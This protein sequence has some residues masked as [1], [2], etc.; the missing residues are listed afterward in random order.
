LS[1]KE[2]E[3]A[4]LRRRVARLKEEARKNEDAWKRAQAREMELLE[5]ETLSVLLQRLTTGLRSGYQLEALGLVLAD[6]DRDIRH[7]LISQGESPDAISGVSFVDTVQW[8]AVPAGKP[9]L[10]PFAPGE[11]AELFSEHEGLR[12]VAL[13][14]LLR[15]E[16]LVGSLNMGSRDPA[17]FTRR[18]ATDFLHHLAVIAAFSLE[19]AINRSHLVRRGFTDVLTGW[20]NRRY[21]EARLSEEL[22][23]CAR[24][25]VALVCL[26]V[27]VD[28][29]KRINDGLGHL[30]GD[31]VLRRL[32]QR[33]E[34]VVRGCDVSARY[35]GEEFVVLL[36]GTEMNA[37]QALAE[38]IR[39]AAAAEPIRLAAGGQ[40]IDVTVS[41]GLA[42][43]RPRGPEEDLSAAGER[44][45]ARA[46]A[47]LYEAKSRG[48]N[49]V[50]LAGNS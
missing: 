25:H 33:M 17:R 20:H 44:L 5:A 48:R 26:I 32:A 40:P 27:D 38:R 14:P 13:L 41:I 7:L 11:H 30:A 23:R 36:P 47:A 35:G 46:D 45:L 1:A 18:L 24:E 10:G 50:A 49:R 34:A 2:L 22:A 29:F 4:G 3:L 12:S 9:W 39:R 15:R 6:P 16:R 37:G 43:Y 31:E 21:L 28:H 42:E 19:S 8:R